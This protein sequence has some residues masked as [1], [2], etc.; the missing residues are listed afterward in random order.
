MAKSNDQTILK[1]IFSYLTEN[2][3]V[4]FATNQDSQPKIRPMVLFYYKGKFYF[5]TF[6]KKNIV[7]II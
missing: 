2:Q 1:E 4:Y 6:K 5:V 7:T 3:Y